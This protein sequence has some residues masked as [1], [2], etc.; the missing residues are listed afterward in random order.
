[1]IEKTARVKFAQLLQNSQAEHLENIKRAVA[2]GKSAMVARSETD[3]HVQA[4]SNKHFCALIRG[5]GELVGL[6]ER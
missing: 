4:Y 3:Q 1:M 5:V 6:V 2:N